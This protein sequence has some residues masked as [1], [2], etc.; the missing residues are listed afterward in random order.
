MEKFEGQYV[1]YVLNQAAMPFFRVGCYPHHKVEDGRI[2]EDKGDAS[3]AIRKQALEAY[4]LIKK[5]QSR[6]KRGKMNPKTWIKSLGTHAILVEVLYEQ[7]AVVA[8]WYEQFN[9]AIRYLNQ[10]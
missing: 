2:V 10:K 6:H 3:Q 5:I 7:K 4:E 1:G 8:E 9:R